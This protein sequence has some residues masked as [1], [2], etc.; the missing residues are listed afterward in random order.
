MKAFKTNTILLI[1]IL[2]TCSITSM[3]KR[4]N[5]GKILELRDRIW[6]AAGQAGT[7]GF[8]GFE[9]YWA[10]APDDQKPN[11][12]MDYYDTWNMNERWSIE[13][14]QELLKFHRKG[15]YVLPQFGINVFYIWQQYLD[16]SQDDELDNLVEG[17][18]YLAI[19][20]FIRIGYEFNNFPGDP[21][22]TPYTPQQ[23][24]QVFTVIAKKIKDANLEVACTF[25]ISLSGH[26]C[27]EF[28][29]GDEWV[30][31][32]GFN[33]F[34]DIAG[35]QHGL[36]LEMCREAAARKIPVMVGEAS[37]M[38]INQVTYN[39]WSWYGVYFKMIA[40]QPTIKQ[41]CYIN[42]DWDVQDMVGGNGMFPWGD[43][44]LQMPGSVKDKFF[45]ELSDPLYFH[46]SSE[47]A[48]RKL[49]FYNDDAAPPPVTNVKREGEFLTWDPV[50]DVGE[51]GLA[52]Y[53]IYKD[54][55]L[56]DYIIGN[57]YP[58][59]DFYQGI[60]A[61]VQVSAM[62]RAGNESP[63]SRTVEVALDKSYELLW[64]GEF[65]YPATSVAVDW[66][67][68]GSQDG[69]AKSPPDDIIIDSTSQIT[70]KYSCYLV[71]EQL[72]PEMNN[73]WRSLPKEY[74]KDW[75]VQLFQCFQ[76]QEGQEYKISFKAKAAE[77]RSFKLYFM[78]HHV[79]SDHTHFPAGRDPN[80]DTEWEF[81]DI[82]D[83]TV[84]PEVKSYEFKSK[85]P[86][87]ETARLSFMMGK[88][89]PTK[90]WIDDVSV[91]AEVNPLHPVAHAGRDTI[92]LDLDDNGSEK[93]VLDA[94][95][96]S[97]N[98]S[99]VSY[100]WKEKGNKIAEGVKP[101][102]TLNSGIHFIE[103]EIK[104]N[105]DNIA[106]D[107]ARVVVT[108]GSPVAIISDPIA[109]KHVV[110]YNA[111]DK[112]TIAL[113]GSLSEDFNGTIT[114]HVWTS[115]GVELAKGKRAEVT[116]TAGKKHA[117]TLTVTDN[118]GKKGTS[119]IDVTVFAEIGRKGTASVSS[120][121]S[122]AAK[123][124][125]DNNDS[126]YWASKFNKESEWA[127]IDLGGKQKINLVYLSWKE[128]FGKDYQIQVSNSADFAQFDVLADVKAGNG[129]K[130]TLFATKPINGQHVRVITSKGNNL[131]GEFKD[132]SGNF[133]ARVSTDSLDPTITF[134]PTTLDRK[135]DI[136]IAIN[137]DNYYTCQPNQ[138]YAVKAQVPDVKPGMEL[139]FKY[140]YVDANNNQQFSDVFTFT[141]GAIGEGYTYQ[142]KEFKIFAGDQVI[143]IQEK[144]TPLLHGNHTLQFRVNSLFQ[145]KK[146]FVQYALPKKGRV[147]ID[148]YSVNGKLIDRVLNTT[149]NHG[150]HSLIYDMSPYSSGIYFFKFTNGN[151]RKFQKFIAL[152]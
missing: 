4:T 143:A 123:N 120:T 149:E 44:R 111:D 86:H 134:V 74:P 118:E 97:D 65:N 84:G 130:D 116:L 7:T 66:K 75:K 117:I 50:T 19:P 151:Q 121:R 138:P 94:S 53:T 145:T 150:N 28:Y 35:G 1:I 30:D 10:I 132:G 31:W 8:D 22:L 47:S 24:A 102:I 72:K 12:F 61:D 103:L 92:V 60:R 133:V 106:K 46:A 88:T 18:K 81:Y 25:D 23:F 33:T 38:K 67:W 21:W 122:G 119:T 42:W 107:K 137:S 36:M 41:M 83:V 99:I 85:A 5:S 59:Q 152:Q 100:T 34:S 131:S 45:K 90:I 105:D 6:H 40:D 64:D 63:K 112:E 29:P 125:N 89:E 70:G 95:K 142:L 3:D 9:N 32:M 17:L 113:D 93:V 87:T 11:V 56:W 80:F 2:I 48:T 110:D 135:A 136:F 146:A 37:P 115:G 14:K 54:G 43:S 27:M 96:S 82:F 62:D 124:I 13:L 16:G 114:S 39:D 144:P 101:T 51:S 104:D 148:L 71:D 49:F 15:Y 128:E 91:R 58:M 68:M 73:W 127:A 76:V 57:K 26:G 129:K 139:S 141:V 78:D 108:N 55:K 98:G 109:P 147:S 69:N 126:T 140:K 77:E 79:N 52:H 20:C